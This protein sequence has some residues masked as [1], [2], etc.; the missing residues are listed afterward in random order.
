MNVVYKLSRVLVTTIPPPLVH[1]KNKFI[2]CAD[3]YPLVSLFQS[4]VQ[5]F[6]LFTF[7]ILHKDVPCQIL[8]ISMGASRASSGRK[9]A[10]YMINILHGWILWQITETRRCIATHLRLRWDYVRAI[11]DVQYWSVNTFTHTNR[12]F[13][14]PAQPAGGQQLFNVSGKASMSMFIRKVQC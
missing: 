4:S 5:P 13:S 11:S 1:M 14:Q 12:Q 9:S 3:F 10:Q 6:F 7:H 2:N 8:I